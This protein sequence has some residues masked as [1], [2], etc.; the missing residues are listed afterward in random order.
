[1]NVFDD[2]MGPLCSQDV[3]ARIQVLAAA[4]LTLEELRAYWPAMRWNQ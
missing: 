2:E 3:A 1:M 4:G